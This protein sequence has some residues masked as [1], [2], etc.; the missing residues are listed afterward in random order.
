MLFQNTIDSLVLKGWKVSTSFTALKIQEASFWL[1]KTARQYQLMAPKTRYWGSHSY[2]ASIFHFYNKTTLYA[3]GIFP[4]LLSGNE[5]EG[6]K[7]Q[8]SF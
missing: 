1:L 5:E 4:L 6:I 8:A 7:N 3:H 2:S